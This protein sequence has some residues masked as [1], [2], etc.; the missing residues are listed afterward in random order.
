MK[1][2]RSK[3][4]A[5]FGA[6]C[7]FLNMP[8][9]YG[10]L[11]K[12]LMSQIKMACAVIG[13]FA[14]A[15]LWA[16][17]AS[18]AAVAQPWIV[19]V[20][21]LA[22]YTPLE[23]KLGYYDSPSD[24]RLGAAVL[25]SNGGDNV[26][27]IYDISVDANGATVD[28]TFSSVVS[29]QVFALGEVC[30]MDDWFIVPYSDNFDLRAIRWNASI[31]EDVAIDTGV[32]NH[33][34][35]DC[36]AFG[37]TLAGVVGLDFDEGEF[38]YYTTADQ[39]ASWSPG[40]SFKP[41]GDSII[42]PFTG[43]FRPKAGLAP[44]ML[45]GYGIGV[46]YQRQTG[47]LESVLL[48]P[49]DGSILGGP[50]GYDSFADHEPFIGNGELKETA[51]VAPS[52]LGSAFGAANG[53]SAIGFSWLDLTTGTADFRLLNSVTTNDLAFQG[54]DIDYTTEP[55]TLFIHTI[56]NRHVRMTY[57]LVAG[58]HTFE[59]I[60]DYP[61]ADHGGPVSLAV[62]ND[63]LYVVATGFP[64]GF[65]G[66]AGEPRLMIATMNP[67]ST[68]MQGQP[69]GMVPGGPGSQAV[70]IPAVQRGG[71]IL[72]ALLMAWFVWVRVRS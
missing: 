31:A 47:P 43:G 42:G 34:M 45:G 56:S 50:I 49:S 3:K 26:I 30:V 11:M 70:S 13:V 53:G 67:D 23:I 37:G 1:S 38:D 40:F 29:G 71:L 33:T 39:G 36:V 9:L 7:A 5:A 64:L 58:T 22:A 27:D 12:Q 21:E 44:L 24:T 17:P 46:T 6:P 41:A 28:N 32:S 4:L 69:L 68:V 15:A 60:P 2:R 10:L 19:S 20:Q 54:L 65:R 57:D 18:I 16:A 35:T 55:D 63:R 25:W 8:K 61:F 48:D 51:G 14:L 66:D 52:P 59:E 62:G 72:L